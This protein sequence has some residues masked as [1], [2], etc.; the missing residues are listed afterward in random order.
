[1]KV[2]G[3]LWRNANR[4]GE[5][6]SRSNAEVRM[7]TNVENSFMDLLEQCYDLAMR[8]EVPDDD[9]PGVIGYFPVYF[10]EELVHAAGLRPH[11]LLGEGKEGCYEHYQNSRWWR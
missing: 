9:Q 1:M 11:A 6:N 2:F 10:P 3:H 7:V 8:L 4:S 5:I